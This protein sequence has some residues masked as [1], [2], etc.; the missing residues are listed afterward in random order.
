MIKC[1]VRA[2]AAAE[3]HTSRKRSTKGAKFIHVFRPPKCFNLHNQTHL[4]VSRVGGHE[5]LHA[6]ER[7]IAVERVGMARRLPLTKVAPNAIVFE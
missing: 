5:S 1:E 6:Y 4:C 7:R 3:A 2:E